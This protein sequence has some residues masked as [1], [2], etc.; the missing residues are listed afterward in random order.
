[1]RAVD[2][3][4]VVANCKYLSAD[5]S[6]GDRW[7]PMEASIRYRRMFLDDGEL[8]T[9]DRVGGQTI[10]AI[11]VTHYGWVRHWRML[12]K[13]W[14]GG[15]LKPLIGRPR[16]PGKAIR[17]R[18]S[19]AAIALAT[20]AGDGDVSRGIEA[21]CALLQPGDPPPVQHTPAEI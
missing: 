1:M 20:A 10:A 3:P 13:P 5:A 12:V 16:L 7:T 14:P 15:I 19:D 6:M 2:N 8:V 17:V 11:L 18:L 4:R 21:A 9:R